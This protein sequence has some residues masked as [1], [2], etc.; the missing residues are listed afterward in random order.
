MPQYFFETSDGV[1]LFRDMIGHDMPDL[2][3]ARHM[4]LRYLPGM[5][6]DTITRHEYP[7]MFVVNVRDEDLQIVY[8]ACLWLT[9]PHF[10]QHAPPSGMPGRGLAH[11][12]GL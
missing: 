11:E 5:A 2:A 10:G 3:A 8:T 1:E 12:A 6:Q 4:A 7:W 9:A